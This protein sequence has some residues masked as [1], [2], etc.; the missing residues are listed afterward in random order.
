M[1][2]CNVN[3]GTTPFAFTWLKDG[4]PI[5]GHNGI[6]VENF[7]DYTSV[8]TIV[9]VDAFTVG[10]YTCRAINE[11]GMDEY[12]SALLVNGAVN[13]FIIYDTWNTKMLFFSL[14][15][16][17][18]HTFTRITVIN[19]HKS[20]FRNACRVTFLFFF[21]TYQTVTNDTVAK[22]KICLRMYDGINSWM[23]QF[24]TEYW[25]IIIYI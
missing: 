5:E 1:V 23:G 10:I 2:I 19:F 4:V 22:A 13:K 16:Y 25:V 8:L 6:S 9:S 18:N 7:D 15:I 24:E 11:F 3:S 14:F 17:K 21:F 12:S 20:C